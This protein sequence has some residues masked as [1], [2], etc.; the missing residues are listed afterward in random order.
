MH[1]LLQRRLV[2]WR[3][4]L[5]NALPATTTVIGLSLAYMLTSTFFVELVFSWP[6]IGQF[7]TTALL[8]VDYPVIMG[9][10]LLAA[11]VFLTINLVVDVVQAR[12]DPRVQLQ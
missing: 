4:A 8:N 7:A 1:Q 5:R 3:L 10:T 9:V 2:V 12:L 6:G 11:I